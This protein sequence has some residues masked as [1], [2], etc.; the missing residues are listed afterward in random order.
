MG[1]TDS[2]QGSKGIQQESRWSET[3]ALRRWHLN[4]DLKL[5][6][7]ASQV[8]ENEDLE[9]ET[10]RQTEQQVQ[11]PWGCTR[12]MLASSGSGVIGAEKPG[13]ERCGI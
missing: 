7:E 9:G 13:G 3:A 4:K 10:S 6:A 2:E 1:E 5:E 11:R 12:G 8:S